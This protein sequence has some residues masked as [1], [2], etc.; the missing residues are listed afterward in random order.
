MSEL[1]NCV[2]FSTEPDAVEVNGP[3]NER[4]ARVARAASG[5]KL[6][7]AAAAFSQGQQNLHAIPPMRER[8]WLR[9]ALPPFLA[10]LAR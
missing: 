2:T 4:R 1:A 6:R 7:R 10:D 8:H 5:R 3:K 9:T